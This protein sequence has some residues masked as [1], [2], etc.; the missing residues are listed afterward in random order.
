MR[1]SGFGRYALISCVAPALLAGCGGPQPP[2]GALGAMPQSR[3][4]ATY[5]DRSGSWMLPEAKR[6]S[7]LYV[8]VGGKSIDV[9]TSPSGKL[10]GTLTGFKGLTSL[11]SDANG[12][13]WV[14][15][16]GGAKGGHLIEYAHGGTSPIATL[17]DSRNAPH[18]CAVDAVTGNLAVAN[19]GS[20]VAVYTAAQ[21]LP[22]YYSTVGFVENVHY[23][24]YDNAG[25][26]YFASSRHH[27]AYLPKGSSSVMKF[28]CIPTPNAHGAYHWDGQYLAVLTQ[29][30]EVWR[31]AISG[32]SAKRVGV[33][34]LNTTWP[35]Y[36][37]NFWVQ[38]STLIAAGE[39][40]GMVYFFKY[41]GGGSPTKTISGVDRP[42][43][44]AVSVAPR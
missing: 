31:Y 1:T 8:D 16:T 11:C 23:I 2:I 10:I 28:G 27:P 34:K 33:V 21:G 12:N 30:R 5:A 6:Q 39:A 3:A 18:S 35:Y 41:P 38:G 15:K 32:R 14:T 4:T 43:A 26:A 13:V 19:R 24:T 42:S 20:N 44:L 9:F 22:T 29:S 36:I 37:A 40:Q 25:S 17:E 7:L